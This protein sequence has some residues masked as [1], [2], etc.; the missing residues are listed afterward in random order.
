MRAKID[1]VFATNATANMP[2]SANHTIA[3]DHGFILKFPPP[4]CAK[5]QAR[6]LPGA[7]LWG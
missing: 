2:L 3:G 6:R 4:A 1:G 7:G 5:L